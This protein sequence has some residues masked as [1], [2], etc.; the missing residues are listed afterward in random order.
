MAAV[1]RGV[2]VP[3]AST[4]SA[5]TARLDQGDAARLLARA[6]G[7]LGDACEPALIAHDLDLLD[8]KLAALT[9]AFPPH[10]LHAV[11]IKANPLVG[12]LRRLVAA[13]AGLEAASAGEL[14]L[15][16]AA[17]CPSARTVFDSPAKTEAELAAAL[18][19]GI[20]INAD[21]Y[22]ELARIER[23]LAGGVRSTSPIGLRV[24][25]E[26]G[27]G[28]IELTD[29]SRSGSKFGV[30]AGDPAA[31][32]AAFERHR[33]LGGLHVHAGSQGY[34]LESLVR[35]VARVA[36]VRD[37]LVARG[38]ACPRFDL[39]GGL[40]AR[41]RADAP[42]VDPAQYRAAL[43]AAVP[44]LFAPGVALTTE[45]GRGLHAGC[46]VALTRVEYVK[47]HAGR[48]TAI[49]H[50]GADLFVRTAYRPD[51]WSHELVLLD[52][53]GALPDRPVEPV[54]VGGPLCFS[55]DVLAREALLPAPRAGDWIA[56]L[57]A[58]AYA[59]GMWSRYCSRA[60]PLVVGVL[61]DDVTVLLARETADDIVRSWSA[62]S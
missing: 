54:Q 1:S 62:P 17:G 47:R 45:F 58:G 43:E 60:M 40:P 11:A 49:V 27:E 10:A 46:A 39:G 51:L 5:W 53:D 12:L 55:G 31:I 6:R 57:D 20:A 37:R 34:A 28:A 3:G 13:G 59:L 4:A 18:A 7:A 19:A 29:V 41:Y 23:I 61:G 9:R 24:N 14:A 16:R 44:S 56:V 48:V 30:P 22:E 8:R 25:P 35:A 33:W 50:V 36:H 42:L 21:A 2:S 15:A 26:L 32:E 52:A 38:H